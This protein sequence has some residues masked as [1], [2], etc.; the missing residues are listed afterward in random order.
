MGVV[1]AGG[2][3]GSSE[4]GGAGGGGSG[5]LRGCQWCTGVVVVMVVVTDVAG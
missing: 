2:T 4:R 3:G 5:R 1:V